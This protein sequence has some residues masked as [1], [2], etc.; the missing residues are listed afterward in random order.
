MLNL[1]RRTNN[2][3][4]KDPTVDFHTFYTSEADGQWVLLGQNSVGWT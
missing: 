2:I 4:E 1:L 3:L